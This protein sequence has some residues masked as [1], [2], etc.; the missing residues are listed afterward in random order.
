MSLFWAYMSAEAYGRYKVTKNNS[1]LIATITGAIA[2]FA[3][4]VSHVIEVLGIGI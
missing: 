3:F 1:L 2:A 4:L